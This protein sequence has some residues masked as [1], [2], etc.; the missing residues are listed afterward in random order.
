[1]KPTLLILA[2]GLGSRYGGLKQLD[3]VGT[4]GETIMD[5][6]IYDAKRAGFGKVVF[7]IR[8][9]F[10]EDFKEKILS[11]YKD[12]I[13][14]D[15]VFQ[16]L[17]MLPEGYTVPEGRVKP[18]GTAHATMVAESKI[19]EPF[20][21]INADDFYGRESFHIMADFLTK[22]YSLNDDTMTILSYKLKN[23]LSEHGTVARGVCQVDNDDYLIDI[24]EHT[25]ISISDGKIISDIDGKVVELS[26]NEPVSMNLMGFPTVAF[27]YFNKYFKKFL[28]EQSENLK[29]EFFLPLV[30]SQVI[31]NKESKVKIL[32]SNAKWFGVTYKEDKPHVV[33][34]IRKMVEEGVYPA[35]L[36]NEN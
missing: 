7:V 24:K 14:V 35:K 9:S 16:D 19:N 20:A 6:S 22:M 13:E 28:D 3:P 1:M 31:E 27:K 5:Y 23:T 12:F 2:A 26:E 17:S 11:K 21:V 18:W 29:S 36:L 10:E 4:S 25:K 30:M 32:E 34:S 15:Y 8:N 33:E